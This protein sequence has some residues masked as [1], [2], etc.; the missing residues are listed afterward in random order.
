MAGS[1]VSMQPSSDGAAPS[2]PTTVG[3][4]TSS[5]VPPVEPQHPRPESSRTGVGE[6][7]RKYLAD[8]QRQARAAISGGLSLA[9]V[10]LLLYY[11][12]GAL[13]YRV[14]WVGVYSLQGFLRTP[15]PDAILPTIAAGLSFGDLSVA[16]YLAVFL[17]AFFCCYW[18][19][20]LV[21]ELFQKSFSPRW[22]LTAQT[23]AAGAYL[24]SPYAVGWSVYAVEIQ[25]F[26][27][28]AAFFLVMALM[29]RLVR[30]LRTPVSF[31][32]WDAAALGIGIGLS[33]PASIPNDAR[34]LVTE[35]VGFV[36][37]GVLMLL[38]SRHAERRPA[39]GSALRTLFLITLPIVVLLL[40]YPVYEAY[41]GGFFVISNVETISHTIIVVTSHSTPLDLSVRLLN[42]HQLAG[43]PYAYLYTTQ[44]LTVAAS[45]LW[46]VLAL[47][48]PVPVALYL[49]IP[50][51]WFVVATVLLAFVS[52]VWATGYSAPFGPV[53]AW[54]TGHIPYGVYAIPPFFA[55][56]Q[57]ASKLYAVLVGFSVVA[58]G[59]SVG[60]W[61]GSGL[62]T[63]SDPGAPTT[64]RGA[65]LLRR[66]RRSRWPAIGVC[67]VLV[68]LLFVAPLPL[69]TGQVFRPGVADSRGFFVPESYF[70]VRNYLWSHGGNVVLLPSITTYVNTM[71]GYHGANDFY[72]A[73]YYPTRVVV[74][75]YY[76]PYAIYLPPAAA[77][78]AEATH[79]LAPGTNSTA[80]PTQVAR[81][82]TV[83]SNTTTT[84]Y[85]FQ[86][87]PRFSIGAADW[88][89]V[90][91]PVSDADQLRQW[92]DAGKVTVRVNTSGGG[93]GQYSFG[94]RAYNSEITSATASQLTFALLVWEPDSG[95]G[96]QGR[97]EVTNLSLTIQEPLDTNLALGTPAFASI[98]GSTLQP[99]WLP[100]M[101][102][103]SVQYVLSDLSVEDI[104]REH[105]IVNDTMSDLV[106]D[107]VVTPV[108]VTPELT[109]WKLTT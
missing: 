49:R 101:E 23:V 3:D 106:A 68:A 26:L 32:R 1:L 41:A 75:T 35:L 61:L 95:A 89:N 72:L 30:S 93:S 58:V 25:V 94:P 6:R 97:G 107:G 67:A 11:T 44:P 85:T 79:P 22:L 109:L 102:S 12:R 47:V 13:L 71:W 108:V 74:P 82:W 86:T 50:D 14:D 31:R 39:I 43:A 36:L 55:I 34:V 24:V 88:L 91:L 62:E 10:L 48:V 84:T 2:P 5:W 16:N 69:Y 105:Q 63:S 60:R 65:A 7:A 9:F 81:P 37:V 57:V 51:R 66:A 80:L 87:N 103:Y 83:V 18:A 28:Q 77:A 21:R 20:L 92:I 54:V 17:D 104:A 76:G 96:Y 19:Q 46:P 4:G 98:Q 73:F 8:P 53:Y 42:I 45:Y 100:L 70:E 59:V 78:Y 38:W 15:I 90:T 29:V 33:M 64:G 99:G 40:I 27:S 56:Q 52:I